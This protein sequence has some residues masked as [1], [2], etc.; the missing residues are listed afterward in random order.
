MNISVENIF[1]SYKP[2]EIPTEELRFL[3]EMITAQIPTDQACIFEYNANS[4]KIER[5]VSVLFDELSTEEQERVSDL[6]RE[7]IIAEVPNIE[8]QIIAI[9]ALDNAS[10]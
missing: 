10:V 7:Y 4:K 2:K 6:V 5:V 1:P 3:L 8:P 9:D